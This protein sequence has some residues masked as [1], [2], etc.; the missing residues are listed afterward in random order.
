[1]KLTTIDLL[2][3]KKVF[4]QSEVLQTVLE[5]KFVLL[6]HEN[7]HILIFGPLHTYN[8]HAQLVEKLCSDRNIDSHWQKQPDIFSI[9]DDS[10][11]I[12]GGGWFRFDFSDKTL[13]AMSISTAYGRFSEEI[14]ELFRQK[15]E[16]LEGFTIKIST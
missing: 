16:L 3:D 15:K 9:T 4:K 11:Q 13:T 8:Y 5:C 2:H 6:S 10:Y 12:N 1:M 14:F 7:E